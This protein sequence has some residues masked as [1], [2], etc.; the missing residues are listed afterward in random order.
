MSFS[1]RF[2]AS[3][4]LA[5][6]TAGRAAEPLRTIALRADGLVA[7]RAEL[8]RGDSRLAV[9][10]AQL[11]D[12][13]DKLLTRKAAS[14]LDKTKTAASGDRHDYF[15]FAP[16]WWPDPAKPDGLPYI[17]H[18]GKVN[19]GSRQGTDRTAFADTCTAVETLGLAY[20]FSGD[21]RY[22]RQAARLTRVWFLEAATRMNPNLEHAQAIPGI[23]HGRGIGIIEARHLTSLID[24][25]ALLAGSPAW[26]AAEAAAMHTW[27]ADYY[28]W[29]TT[30]K[31]GKDE[32][33]AENNHGSWYDVQATSLALALGRHDDAKQILAA[34]PQKRIAR[35]IEPDGRQPLELERT[36]SLNYSLFNLE[37]LVLLARLGDGVGL[38]LWSFATND[39]RSLRAA[40]RHV[41]PYVD[42]AK[43]WL[44]ED[45]DH[46]DRDRVPPL[47]AEGIL[48]GNEAS[49]RELITRF[50]AT[51]R[52]TERWRLW[53]TVPP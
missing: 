24:G 8:A 29:L 41:A 13:A 21:E 39:G 16:Y 38:D 27:L 19:P 49:L 48:H 23:N 4:V 51:P 12:E 3:F 31:N 26:P 44:K 6:F 14:V 40:L 32:A 47:L 5:S 11:R 28:R 46:A 42:P 52:P 36:R 45:L 35:Q 1:F 53:L 37:A 17:R 50:A 20:W 2:L 25:L 30:S 15:S 33:A 18:D 9:P 43:A 7:A 10:F 34:V 22:A